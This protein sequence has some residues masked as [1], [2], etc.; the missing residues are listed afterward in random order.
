[1]SDYFRQNYI[2][3]SFSSNESWV[4]LSEIEQRIKAKIEA[5]VSLLKIGILASIVEYLLDIMK[6]LLSMV[7]R[8][9]SLFKK[10]PNLLKLYDLFVY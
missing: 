4:V 2:V 8:K 5:V 1:M 10:I 9:M 6:H 3:T 7:R